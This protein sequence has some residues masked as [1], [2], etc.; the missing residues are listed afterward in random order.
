MY[1]P[2]WMMV[3]SSG[4]K[5]LSLTLLVIACVIMFIRILLGGL[6]VKS[7]GVVI[8]SFSQVNIY[9]LTLFIVPF[10]AL[11]FGRRMMADKKDVNSSGDGITKYGD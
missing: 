10:I 5:S 9:G 7:D 3:D 8:L 4:R 1:W 2:R 6:V 11:Y